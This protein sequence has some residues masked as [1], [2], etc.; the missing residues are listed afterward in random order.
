VLFRAI[1]SALEGSSEAAV[2][3]RR[4][5]RHRP[6]RPRAGKVGGGAHGQRLNKVYLEYVG[7]D[8]ILAALD[9]VLAHYAGDRGKGEPL[10]DFTIR[11]GYVAEVREGR[12][13]ND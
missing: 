2:P 12:R 3:R 7:E 5:T 1:A 4:S 11:A 6:H 8:A 13:F 9:R 10:G